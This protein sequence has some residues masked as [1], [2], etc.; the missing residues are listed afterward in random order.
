MSNEPVRSDPAKRGALASP[1]SGVGEAASAIDL[2]APTSMPPTPAPHR[3]AAAR[4]DAAT[5]WEGMTRAIAGLDGP[6]AALNLAAL[7]YN[8][9]DLLLRAAGTPIRIASKSIRIRAVADAVLALPGYAGILAFTLPEA[10]WLAEHGRTDIV[11]GYPTVNRRAL[12]ALVA[13]PRAA[14][15]ITLMVDDLAQLD[16]VDAVAGPGARPPIRVAIDA[17]ASWRAPGPLGHV[18]VRRS[19]VHTPEEVVALARGILARPG[20]ALVG[21][22]MY[23][24]QIAGQT[25]DVA[26]AAAE[27]A[28]MRWMKR[29]SL[30]E[31]GD[32]RGAIV[33]GVRAL[34]PLE[35]VNAGGTGSIETSAADPSVTEVTAGSGILGGHL[36]DGYAAFTPA[37]AAAF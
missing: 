24:A 16:V 33:D 29:R 27:N 4:R 30:A 6:I 35:F 22:M 11:L 9:H 28:L 10:L 1:A 7:R 23:E 34:A 20:F 36:F 14:E 15:R 37:P 25:D 13:D 21:L 19:P 31:L 8:A 2:A 17:D 12:A 5:A 26:G 3:D 32:R 18:G